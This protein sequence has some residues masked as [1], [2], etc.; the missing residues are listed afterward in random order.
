MKVILPPFK[1][2]SKDLIVKELLCYV[3]SKYINKIEKTYKRCKS[4]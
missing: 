2:D 1:L 4:I 3:I